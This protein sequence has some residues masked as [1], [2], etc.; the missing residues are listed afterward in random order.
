MLEQIGAEVTGSALDHTLAG[1]VRKRAFPAEGASHPEPPSGWGGSVVG[2]K[3]KLQPC[4]SGL[5]AI[6]QGLPPVIARDAFLH[7]HLVGFGI[8]FPIVCGSGHDLPFLISLFRWV[9]DSVVA[10]RA[11]LRTSR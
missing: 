4:D 7:R 2:E 3:L 1:K 5:D 8:A 9:P 11:P 6:R 10:L